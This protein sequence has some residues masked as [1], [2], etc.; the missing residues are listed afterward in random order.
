MV[1]SREVDDP[2]DLSTEDLLLRPLNPFLV[3]F[4]SIGGS[5]AHATLVRSDAETFN[6]AH[7]HR[8][9][10]QLKRRR[11]RRRNRY[12]DRE[13]LVD[14]DR[15][16]VLN[17]RFPLSFIYIYIY[18]IQTE[19]CLYCPSI[20]PG[21]ERERERAILIVRTEEKRGLELE[22]YCIGTMVEI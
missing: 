8:G 22:E 21:E 18:V 4:S 17:R 12:R 20:F 3:H 2:S 9:S 13:I 19:V 14:P 7:H 1:R 10:H 15:S 11:R 6:R 5:W 16:I